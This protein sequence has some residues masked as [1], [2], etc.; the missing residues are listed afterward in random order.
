MALKPLTVFFIFPNA[1][2]ASD[3]LVLSLARDDTASVSAFTDCT[4]KVASSI[5]AN[6]FPS[7]VCKVS[8]TNRCPFI[9]LTFFRTYPKCGPSPSLPAWRTHSYRNTR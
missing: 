2:S 6:H 3:L 8:L 9:N 1:S 4:P 7:V 5:T